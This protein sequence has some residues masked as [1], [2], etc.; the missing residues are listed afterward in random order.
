MNALALALCLVT[1]GVGEDG[2]RLPGSRISTEAAARQSQ[3]VAVATVVDPV[4]IPIFISG[5]VAYRFVKLK[6]VRFLKGHAEGEELTIDYLTV[7][8]F[9]DGPPEVAVEKDQQFIW[10]LERSG[11]GNL[12]SVKLLRP[13][14]KNMDAVT[15]IL[16]REVR[17]TG[18][19]LSDR[20]A[21]WRCEAIVVGTLLEPGQATPGPDAT[22]VKGAK[23]RVKRALVGSDAPFQPADFTFATAPPTSAETAPVVGPEYVFFIERKPGEHPRVIKIVLP[24]AEE[25]LAIQSL[26]AHVNY[27]R[28]ERDEARM[29]QLES[30]TTDAAGRGANRPAP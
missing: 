13:M 17:L 18:S 27:N 2:P 16:R 3:I 1:I 5:G 14:R 20:L 9:L 29:K 24:D 28:K 23:I 30:G 22:A 12:D 25:L 11:L 21:A 4:G 19:D 7:L 26:A 15:D 8:S 6:E 10:F